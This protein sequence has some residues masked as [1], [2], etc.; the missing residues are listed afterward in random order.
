MKKLIIFFI[1]LGSGI[2]LNLLPI[3]TSYL[4]YIGNVDASTYIDKAKNI[5]I[6][7]IS[8]FDFF[9]FALGALNWFSLPFLIK[10]IDIESGY[11]RMMIINAAILY[12]IIIDLNIISKYTILS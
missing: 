8:N 9:D 5:D 4:P 12:G 11:W 7:G 1:F 10:V 2:A 3:Q 6:E